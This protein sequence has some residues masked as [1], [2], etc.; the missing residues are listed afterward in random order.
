MI[1]R[2]YLRPR[3]NHRRGHFRPHLHFILNLLVVHPNLRL[4]ILIAPFG[5]AR[6]RYELA[7][8]ALAS[9]FKPGEDRA[10]PIADR[11][12]VVLVTDPKIPHKEIAANAQETLDADY[13]EAI[14]AIWARIC[15]EWLAAL[16]QPDSPLWTE[17]Q[18]NRFSEVTPGA[19][20]YDVGESIA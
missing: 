19:I 20:T 4:K 12:Q 8:P 7:L 3:L 6:V 10:E 16:W 15:P 5:I 9:L 2:G 18:P 11:L 1:I 17:D 14:E 13:F